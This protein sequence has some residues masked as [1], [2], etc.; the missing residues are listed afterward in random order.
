ME[1]IPSNSVLTDVEMM[2]VA[3]QCL[4]SWNASNLSELMTS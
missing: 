1:C 2:L 3:F 4:T